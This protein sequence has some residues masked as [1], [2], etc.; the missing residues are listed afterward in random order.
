MQPDLFQSAKKREKTPSFERDALGY[1]IRYARR[2]KGRPFSAE[3]VTLAAA[4]SGLSPIDLRQW[5]VIFQ[6]AAKD[7]H[8]RRSEVL[9]RRAMGNGSLAPGWVA[10]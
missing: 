3:D 8:I 9:F 6:Q 5:G 2:M 7:G 4:E 10:A 1:L